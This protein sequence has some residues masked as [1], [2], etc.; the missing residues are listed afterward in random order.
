LEVLPPAATWRA[1]HRL[2][3]EWAHDGYGMGVECVRRAVAAGHP[4]H[5][6]RL[7]DAEARAP[8]DPYHYRIIWQTFHGLRDVLLP[9]LGDAETAV[10]PF[11]HRRLTAGARRALVETCPAST[12]RR[13]GLPHRLY[14]RPEGGALGR[15]RAAV[16]RAIVAS[17]GARV[18]MA[19]AD[20]RRLMRDPGGDA[21]DAVIAGAGAWEA[22]RAKD[23]AALA[24]HPRYGREGHLYY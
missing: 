7:T 14:K 18:A 1:P 17:L 10:L 3:R 5:V 23:H 20:V 15:R 19:A 4:M 21:L 16:R 13:W 12:L 6:R 22:V 8:F 24:R 9:L 2:V 11:Q